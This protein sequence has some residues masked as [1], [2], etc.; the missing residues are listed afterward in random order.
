MTSWQCVLIAWG[1]RY[2]V[3]EINRLVAS[4]RAQSQGPARFV[5]LSDRPREGLDPGVELRP[6]PDWF[7]APEFRGSGCQAKLCLFEPGVVPDDLPAIYLD[8]DTMVLGDLSR[9]LDVMETPQT[10]AMLQSAILPFG[11]FAR[12]LYRVTGQRR[13]ARGNS[14]IVVYHPAHTG[15][16]AAR[17]REL[18]SRPD[19]R[20]FKPLRADE[21]F[22]SWVAQPVMRAVPQRLVVKFPTEYMQPWRWLVHLRASLPWIRRRRA[23]LI[24]VTFPGVRLK[25]EDLAALPE[26]AMVADRKGRR[27]FW[28]D[29]ALGGL[30]R[31][32]IE[33]YG[34][35]PG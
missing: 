24:A 13:Y 3:A 35:A 15:F 17:F 6:I 10:V 1:D 2:P 4:I 28:T 27:L 22:I 18:S 7:L 33:H 14:S 5:L 23:G 16:I 34:R 11:A 31:R 19:A 9:L 26:G 30:R 29:R 32:I 25:G 20:S 8:L 12:W 21:R